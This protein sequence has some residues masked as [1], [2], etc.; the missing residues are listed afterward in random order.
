MVHY[1]ITYI[2]ILCI[3]ESTYNID[4]FANTSDRFSM[5]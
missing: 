5:T 4:F 3:A 1:C 2:D